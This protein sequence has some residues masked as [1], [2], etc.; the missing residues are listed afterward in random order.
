MSARGP[1][2]LAVLTMTAAIQEVPPD[3]R[4]CYELETDH[5]SETA[6]TY[7]EA[8]GRVRERLQPGWRILWLRVDR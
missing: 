8:L 3:H 6:E 2:L 4:G 1:T 7:D 5:L